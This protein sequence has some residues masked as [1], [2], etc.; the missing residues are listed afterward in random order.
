MFFECWDRWHGLLVIAAV[1]LLQSGLILA[2]L[3]Q[4]RRC[5]RYLETE[6]NRAAA[7]CQHQRQQLTHLTRVAILGQLS[8][9]LAHE[10]NQPLTSI[11]SNAQ[12]AQ[13]FLAKCPID[14]TEVREILENIVS[15]DKRAGEVISRL[16]AMLKRGEN[17]MQEIDVPRLI[18]DA[19]ALAHSDLVVRQVQIEARLA[20]NVLPV[21]GD[22]VQIQ[23]VLLNLL[24][25]AAEAM[26]AND[27][28]D[29]KITIDA[30]QN[31]RV[32]YVAVSDCGAGI[33]DGSLERVFDAFYTTKSD[34]L[35]LGL[36]ICR[37]I[38]TGHGGRLWATNNP[39]R[40]VT[41]HFI[42]PLMGREPVDQEAANDS[43]PG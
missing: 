35:G 41:F 21:K 6:R 17:Q 40:G 38:I 9:A 27:P 29:R 36:A 28:R 23:Q 24:L 32:V 43:G 5:R 18:R 19:L 33:T 34:G 25:N 42:L 22:G 12:A 8:G 20:Q 1:T 31:A 11:L 37:S 10:L 30:R 16:R 15:D 14:L 2:L 3:V 4:K 7:E 26:N 13:R 39:D